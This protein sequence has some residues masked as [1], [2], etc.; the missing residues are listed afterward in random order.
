MHLFR[1]IR[2][3]RALLA[4]DG[5]PC[6][7][8]RRKTSC[9]FLIASAVGAPG[10]RRSSRRSGPRAPASG[11]RRPSASRRAAPIA[12][13][14]TTPSP[15]GST[16]SRDDALAEA[17][18][19]FPAERLAAQQAQILRRLEALERPAR[20]IAFP[21]LPQP[22]VTRPVAVRSAGSQP[23][24]GGRSD[25]RPRRSASC[26]TCARRS[27]G[28]RAEPAAGQPDHPAARQPRGGSVDRP[29]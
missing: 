1:A 18:D 6:R 24:R 14:A 26:S 15:A 10:R 28:T 7:E 5:A 21:K 23:G 2:K 17:D 16:T 4:D 11:R 9:Q 8:C 29:A 27:D 13:R 19:V 25:R 22:A 20:V 3:L 12:A